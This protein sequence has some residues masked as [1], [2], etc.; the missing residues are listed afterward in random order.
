M[1]SSLLYLTF[2]SAVSSASCL[3][4]DEIENHDQPLNIHTSPVPRDLEAQQVVN[5]NTDVPGCVDNYFR[6]SIGFWQIA[7]GWVD[8]GVTLT[9]GA[10]TFLAGLSTLGDLDSTTRTS[11]GIAA[12]ACGGTATFLQGLRAYSI[13]AIGDRER[14]LRAVILRSQPTL[15]T[16]VTH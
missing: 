8:L 3:A 4:M 13:K 7:E 9:M 14:S 5:L 6:C 10:T 12:V 1:K 2:L 16:V 11:L 15:T